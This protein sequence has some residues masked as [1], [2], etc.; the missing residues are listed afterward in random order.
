M[1]RNRID[2]RNQQQYPALTNTVALLQK[3]SNPAANEY[4]GKKITPLP[5]LTKNLSFCA[6]DVM[7]YI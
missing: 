4:I 3:L 2:S 1:N 5:R 6:D 7:N